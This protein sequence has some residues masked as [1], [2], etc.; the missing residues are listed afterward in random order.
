M[1]RLLLICVGFMCYSSVSFG[2]HS[3]EVPLSLSVLGTAPTL[4]ENSVVDFKKEISAGK[5]ESVT[6]ESYRLISSFKS[7]LSLITDVP[8]INLS[9]GS[10]MPIIDLSKGYTSN[11]PIKEFSKNFPSKMPITELKSPNL[12]ILPQK[13][14]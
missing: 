12:I 8:E 6:V 4:L 11:F 9:E 3:F 14:R 10:N 7:G 13:D 5:S 1:N 2:Q